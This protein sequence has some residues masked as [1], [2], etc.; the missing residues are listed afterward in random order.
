[1]TTFDKIYNLVAKIPKGNVS[2]Y[3]TLAKIVGINPR[4]VGYILHQNKDPKN[5]PCHRIIKSW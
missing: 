4:T 2:T 3:G 5:I 1:M